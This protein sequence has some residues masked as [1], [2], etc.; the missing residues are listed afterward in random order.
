MRIAVDAMGGDDAP[1]Q[2]VA[3]TVLA[4]SGNKGIHCI[5]VGDETQVSAELEKQG[6]VPGN[7]STVHASDVIEMND[8]PVGSL[9]RKPDSSVARAIKMVKDGEADAVISG[10]NTGAMVASTM[11]NLGMLEGV[12]RAG[13]CA[14]IPTRR[15]Q[16]FLIDVGANIN[17]KPEHLLQYGIMASTYARE[18]LNRENPRVAL[19]SVGEE[20]Q[21]G[22]GLVKTTRSL[23]KETRL[24]FMG[25][26]EGSDIFDSEYDVI[27]CDGFIGNVILKGTEALGESIIHRMISAYATVDAKKEHETFFGKFMEKITNFLDYSEYGGAPLLGV[28]GISIICH[29][30]SDAK[31]IKNAIKVATLCVER[32]INEHIKN[33]ILYFNSTTKV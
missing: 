31:A 25:N 11:M 10:G 7:I 24:N 26:A 22:N 9:K 21:K 15:G 18:A 2:V 28:N 23:F 13:I 4:A 12:R 27:V 6:E 3:G 16:K 14:P 33:E 20:N 17:C 30:R 32:N 8:P 29:G 19:L 5:L 1:R